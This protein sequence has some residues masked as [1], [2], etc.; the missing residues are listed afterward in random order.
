MQRDAQLG[1]F[2]RFQGKLDI[3][4]VVLHQQDIGRRQ[5]FDARHGFTCFGA[6]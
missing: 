5:Y 3:V 2:E 1:I 4:L 6:A